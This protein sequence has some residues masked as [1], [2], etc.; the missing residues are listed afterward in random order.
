MVVVVRL[1]PL[2]DDDDEEARGMEGRVEG[3]VCLNSLKAEATCERIA[4]PKNKP[5]ITEHEA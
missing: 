2:S 4:V 5:K 3:D 1:M